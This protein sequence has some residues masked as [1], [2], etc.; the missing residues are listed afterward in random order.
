MMSMARVRSW[1]RNVKSPNKEGWTRFK[2]LGS[3]LLK[4]LPQ[5]PLGKDVESR[6]RL[7]EATMVFKSNVEKIMEATEKEVESELTIRAIM[8]LERAITLA[9]EQLSSYNKHCN[10]E[11]E[12]IKEDGDSDFNKTF[13]I[14]TAIRNYIEAAEEDLKDINKESGIPREDWIPILEDVGKSSEFQD[15]RGGN[16]EVS[17]N[18]MFSAGGDLLP[19]KN[20]FRETKRHFPFNKTRSEPGTGKRKRIDQNEVKSEVK[21]MK[22]FKDIL[23]DEK[24]AK[25]IAKVDIEEESEES[26]DE[27]E[28]DNGNV[29]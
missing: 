29:I 3:A 26:Y 16:S 25:E 2:H 14:E 21:R 12:M 8:F 13:Q 20:L 6:G 7:G 10:K 24:L 15:W 23:E 27:V 11:L 19:R 4:D 17:S 5:V 1:V 9:S 28:E 22:I 18:M